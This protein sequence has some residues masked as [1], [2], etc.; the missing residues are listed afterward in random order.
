MKIMVIKSSPNKDGLTES[1]G[2]AAKKGIEKGNSEAI[3]VCLNDLNILKCKAC[4]QGWGICFETDKCILEDDFEQVHEAMGEVDGF[5]VVTPVYFHDMSES[6][7]TFFDRLRRCEANLKFNREKVNKIE[8]KPVIC[9]AAA[10][11]MG[12]GTISCLASMERLFF[13]MNK[14]DYSNLTKFDYIGVTRRNK[15]YM[16]DAIE[17]SAL[18]IVNGD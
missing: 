8:R 12:T 2:K 18:R 17:S 10:G 15:E 4:D 6:A 1:C 9:V 3:M 14:L 16:L 7:K 5:V 11:G 13:H